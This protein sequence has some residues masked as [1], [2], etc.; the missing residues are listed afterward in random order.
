[1]KTKELWLIVFMVLAFVGGI[2]LGTVSTYNKEIK[3]IREEYLKESN[4]LSMDI[5]KDLGYQSIFDAGKVNKADDINYINKLYEKKRD[6]VI[7]IVH[8]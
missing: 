3:P 4:R 1:M 8:N 7:N 2:F 5:G 6:S